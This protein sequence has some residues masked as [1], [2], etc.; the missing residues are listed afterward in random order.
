MFTLQM[1]VSLTFQSC[2][3]PQDPSDATTVCC[4]D[5]NYKDPWPNMN[6]NGGGNNRNNGNNNGNN[7]GYSQNNGGNGI[8]PRNGSGQPQALL[9]AWQISDQK[10]LEHRIFVNFEK[11]CDLLCRKMVDVF[12]FI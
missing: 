5:P 3:N 8:Q 12:F 1:K 2:V 4:R 9:S 10:G 6:G 11:Y 7:R